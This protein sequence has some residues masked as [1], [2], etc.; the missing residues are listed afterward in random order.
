[1]FENVKGA[2]RN[3]IATTG[4]AFGGAG[5]PKAIA[6]RMGAFGEY[7]FYIPDRLAL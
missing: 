2:S 3:G 7:R 5:S 4:E 1:L 6:E